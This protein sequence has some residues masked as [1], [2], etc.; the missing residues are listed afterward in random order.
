[1]VLNPSGVPT[2]G[3]PPSN[4]TATA[5]LSNIGTPTNPNILLSGTYG[6]IFYG[7]GVGTG[8][9]YTNYGPASGSPDSAYVLESQGG[10]F[11]PIWVEVSLNTAT[12]DNWGSQIV[13]TDSANTGG[14]ENTL[15]GQGTLAHPLVLAQQGAITSPYI[16]TLSWNG[17]TWKPSSLNASL[18]KNSITTPGS[19]IIITNGTNQVVGG[20]N[21]TLDIQGTSG[22]LL[23]GNGGGNSATFTS[24]GTNGQVFTSNGASTPSWQPIS[25][26]VL[27]GLSGN[28]GTI[29]GTN[30]I[31]TLDDNQLRFYSGGPYP[32]P[33]G[34]FD[35]QLVGATP[36]ANTY[37]GTPNDNNSN[38][39]GAGNNDAGT[40]NVGVGF[41]C[42]GFA[43]ATSTYNVAMGSHALEPINVES[44]TG[45]YNVSMGASSNLDNG[46][47]TYET[48]IGAG[49][50]EGGIATGATSGYNTAVGYLA[51][52]SPNAS[53]TYYHAYNTALGYHAIYTPTAG[54]ANSN[55]GVG[56][57]A[58]YQS[59][60]NRNTAAGD[61]AL[62]TNTT[63]TNNTALGYNAEMSSAALTNAIAIGYNA[64]APVSNSV[65]LGTSSPTVSLY[66][67]GYNTIG[68]LYYTSAASGK[69]SA[70]TPST[71]G[72]MLQSNG[73]G[74]APAW[75]NV[76]V[77]SGFVTNVTGTSPIIVNGTWNI[78]IQGTGAN[79]G[80]VLY[81][82][83]AGNSAEFTPTGTSGTYLTS[84]GAGVPTWSPITVS[85]WSLTGNLG[86]I[87]GTNYIGTNDDKQF[88]FYTDNAYSGSLDPQTVGVTTYGNTYYGEARTQ[89]SDNGAG[90][91]D[92]GTYNVALG[93]G[94]LGQITTSSGISTG[95]VSAGG[96]S[97]PCVTTGSYNIGI[98]GFLALRYGYQG[99]ADIALG[100]ESLYELSGTSSYNIGIGS[101]AG[102]GG[103]GCG[104]SNGCAT[105]Y[106]GNFNSMLGNYALYNANSNQASNTAVGT[107]ASYSTT[108]STNTSVGDSALYTN[109]SGKYNVALGYA[110][111]VSS[112]SL[113][114]T[115]VVG[116][117]AYA[118]TSNELLLGDISGTNGATANTN[119]G[120]GTQ[121]PATDAALAVK[122]GHLESQGQLS[123]GNV[124]ADAG[125]GSLATATINSNATDVSGSITLTT[126]SSGLSSGQEATV[127]FAT[128]YTYTPVVTITP[129][130]AAAAA[131]IN[132]NGAYVS[133]GTASFTI[134]FNSTP[135]AS[136]PY[137]FNYFIIETPGTVPSVDPC[138]IPITLTNNQSAATPSGFQQM[139]TVNSA[140]Y[141]SMEMSGLQN[142]EFTVGSPAPGGTALQAWLESGN[143]SASS[144][145]IWWVNLGTNTIGA[146]GG[147]LTIY[148]NFMSSSVLN[149]AGPTG[150]APQLSG[151]YAQYDNGSLVFNNYWNFN[152][153]LP[154]GL[155]FT[156]GSEG[157]LSYGSNGVTM[158]I[159]SPAWGT[160][161]NSSSTY[162][163]GS[164]GIVVETD[165]AQNTIP[166]AEAAMAALVATPGISSSTAAY[167]GMLQE[168]SSGTGGYAFLS[169][170]ED[171][172]GVF[173]GNVIGAYATEGTSFNVWSLGI[174]SSGTLGFGYV[175]YGTTL[176]SG[177]SAVDVLSSFHIALQT[178][179]ASATFSWLRTRNYPP[180]A[181]MPSA[182]YGS[183][184]CSG[185]SQPSETNVCYV[186]VTLHNS[187]SSA[188]PSN[189]PQLVTVN[190]SLYSSLESAGLQNVEFSTGPGGTGTL[191]QAWLE[192][193]NT[194]SSTTTVWWVN[195][196]SNTIAAGNSLTIYM[197]F[198]TSNVMSALGPTGE[199]P[200][201]SGTYAQYDN[202][203]TVFPT[204]YDNFAG[205]SLASKWTSDGFQTV[206]VN[207]GVTL[208][209]VSSN[210][211]AIYTNTF[212]AALNNVADVYVE[213]SNP[214]GTGA[215]IN[216]SGT[217]GNGVNNGTD[218]VDAQLDGP[219]GTGFAFGTGGSCT[220][221]PNANTTYAN[222]APVANTFYA[223]SFYMLST[224]V[225]QINYGAF[226]TVT[227][228]GV[229]LNAISPTS[230]VGLGVAQS[231]T[232][233]YQWFRIRPTLANSSTV[234]SVS[235]GE[236]NCL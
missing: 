105:N 153:S 60:S 193:G 135:A 233:T 139:L 216:T 144:S 26:P 191:L 113:T 52:A 134:N 171:G 38:A 235:L 210:W 121:T 167:A 68:S 127:F 109:A 147:T 22:G 67:P 2:W 80:G 5:P 131:A 232:G 16:S 49:A 190:S 205:I 157:S 79:S 70:L 99:N 103:S 226:S 150:E 206:A 106:L 189:Y 207:N 100:Y 82:A 211:N 114:N 64:S 225:L 200:Q 203:A 169:D 221:A 142:V 160:Y 102:F 162:T 85:A 188:T 183:S 137:I 122:K 12:P 28:G 208:T 124:F 217:N 181:T 25:V 56:T 7:T 223:L 196:G 126:G 220:T 195:M 14:V 43:A 209:Y 168:P 45:S 155:T 115:T 198:M 174:N 34:S 96:L 47:A 143:S 44:Q 66:L 128:S 95:N 54:A 91:G 11:P 62:Y 151:T 72:Y 87:P 158:T 129:G 88:R 13:V 213:A 30:F 163:P 89:N 218:G 61:S 148:M 39:E 185:P 65:I 31:G 152:G 92:A 199:A 112:G 50:M 119:V 83:G 178:T 81:S 42:M 212:S 231:S 53:S 116:A 86:T 187:T 227:G 69:V 76:T 165:M 177:A 149:S 145:T 35:P 15:N 8:S 230:A 197:N 125:A 146:S 173:P 202:G 215:C 133:A 36:Y 6:G 24:G 58:V 179:Q 132:T 46:G 194:T 166:A 110:A 29:P 55:T 40:Y 180:S 176:S 73:P 219:S 236:I 75:A 48:S 214:S 97:L 57:N 17:T 93:N 141:S 94:S 77:G 18:I 71:I 161:I 4:V 32:G 154:S 136:T 104:A 23:A 120:I 138:Y 59:T 204:F 51:L 170:Y 27:W 111:N 20:S 130:N 33:A 117:R 156:A 21:V 172:G 234:P 186:P 37:L 107:Y 74:V 101:Y 1:M 201:L 229:A 108:A 140:S 98:G 175:N 192:S 9:S 63:G 123:A 222:S 3:A 184:T 19:A 78:N 159:A 10:A 90:N 84:A 182:L 164:N 118:S 228:T 224:P 41:G